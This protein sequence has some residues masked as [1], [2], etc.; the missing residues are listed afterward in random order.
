[1]ARTSRQEWAKRVQ[2]W[3]DSGLTAHEFAAEIG[4]KADTLRHWSWQLNHEARNSSGKPPR[5][6]PDGKQL[7]AF[8]EVGTVVT[9]HAAFEITLGGAVVRVPVD[10]DAAALRRLLDVVSGAP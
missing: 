1:M 2:C 7:P 9:S 3:K 8:V 4:V 6:K 5:E 10:F